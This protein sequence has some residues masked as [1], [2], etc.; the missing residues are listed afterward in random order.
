MPAVP[1]S[2]LVIVHE[3]TPFLLRVATYV[4]G[5]GVILFAIIRLE[6]GLDDDIGRQRAGRH[7]LGAI[8]QENS[9][10]GRGRVVVGEEVAERLN[11]TVALGGDGER[12]GVWVYELDGELADED[13]AVCAV[14]ADPAGGREA[15]GVREGLGAA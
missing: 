7:E 10:P 1:L 11:G 3:S 6:V 15:E 5:V 13:G 2:H 14:K 12:Y 8:L 4:I 9:V